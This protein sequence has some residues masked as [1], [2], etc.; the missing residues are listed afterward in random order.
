MVARRKSSFGNFQD[1]V[2][3]K[4]S[5][6]PQKNGIGKVK[7]DSLFLYFAVITGKNKF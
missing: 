6:I 3:L 1:N 5:T 2:P 7:G 4:D